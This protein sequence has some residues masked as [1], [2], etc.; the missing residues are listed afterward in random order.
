MKR[1]PIALGFALVIA[2][3]AVVLLS[4]CRASGPNRLES[5]LATG[6]KKIT[7]GG[8]D[9]KN[10]IPSTPES[11]KEGAE[12]FQHH[13]QVCH[14]LDGHNTGVPF[15]AKMSPPV[16]DLGEKDVQDY[17]DGQLKWIIDNGIRFT[18]MPGWSGIL[19]DEEK[20]HM[21]NF[22]RN[23]PQK[24][25]LGVPD[26][27]REGGEEHQAVKTGQSASSEKKPHKHSHKTSNGAHK[28]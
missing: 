24:G 20:W 3:A 17:S 13:C 11:V 28:H 26:V 6:A 15:A 2:L 12:H 8:K 25:T 7:I 27:Y 9:W 19:E 22:I 10:P 21:V 18:G 4:S 16:R 14:G 5:E 23:L 1:S